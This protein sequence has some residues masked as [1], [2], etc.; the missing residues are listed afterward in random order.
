MLTTNNLTNTFGFFDTICFQQSN[1]QNTTMWHSK[2]VYKL[3]K[4]LILGQ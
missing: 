1:Q 3:T 2:P 4:I